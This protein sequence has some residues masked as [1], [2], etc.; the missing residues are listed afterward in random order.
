MYGRF[1][2]PDP[3]RDQHFENTQSWNIYS[4]CLNNPVM[5]FD[6]D[7]MEVR[8]FSERL[9]QSLGGIGGAFVNARHS[10]MRVTTDKYD[11]V[12]ERGGDG[13]IKISNWDKNDARRGPSDNESTVV[14]PNGVGEKDYSFEN[15]ILAL[16]KELKGNDTEGYEE[17]QKS[18][19]PEATPPYSFESA[20]CNGFLAFLADEN[21]GKINFN[22]KG[23]DLTLPVL[24]GQP[25]VRGKVYLESTKE[26][27]KKY[28]EYKK[29][30]EEEEKRKKKDQS[31]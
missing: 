14:R 23:P 18:Q 16:A 13:K 17:H 30:R 12:I 20:N 25:L 21:G 11:K 7:G 6:P 5:N 3:A 1:A 10:W 8:V 31:K 26:Y 4:Y 29:K 9:W 24:G 19:N 28:Q 2:S 15:G 22:Q 27:K